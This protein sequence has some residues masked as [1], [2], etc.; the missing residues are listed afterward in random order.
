MRPTI[1]NILPH[2]IDLILH[3]ES[4]NILFDLLRQFLRI[5]G[6]SVDVV[7][8]PDCYFVL[9]SVHELEGS[10]DSVVRVHHRKV[11]VFVEVADVFLAH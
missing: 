7:A 5:E 4:R 2:L 11:A 3:L 6:D 1:R 10:I 8:R 9:G